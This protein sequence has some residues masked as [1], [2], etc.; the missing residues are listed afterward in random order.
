M[1]EKMSFLEYVKE[2]LAS[3]LNTLKSVSLVG[4]AQCWSLIITMLG[5]AMIRVFVGDPYMFFASW[6]LVGGGFLQFMFWLFVY[7]DYINW[8]KRRDEK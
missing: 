5:L 4:R 3:F 2:K 8:K 6:I 1:G 7:P